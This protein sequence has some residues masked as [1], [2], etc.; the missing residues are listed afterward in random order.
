MWLVYFGLHS[1]FILRTQS[2]VF[3]SQKKRMLK[4]EC[5]ILVAAHGHFCWIW[6]IVYSVSLSGL[7]RKKVLGGGNGCPRSIQ[8]N[9]QKQAPFPV[10]RGHTRPYRKS[11]ARWGPG[12][13]TKVLVFTNQNLILLY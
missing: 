4:L 10:P 12:P 2:N 1:F 11:Q 5:N 8:R 9:L 13:L 3:K 6:I 7:L